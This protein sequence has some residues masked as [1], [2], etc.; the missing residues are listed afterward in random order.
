ML[1]AD[2]EP[3]HVLEVVHEECPLVVMSAMK[4]SSVD[5][6]APFLR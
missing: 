2:L 3:V 1:L 5:S 6:V 4:P